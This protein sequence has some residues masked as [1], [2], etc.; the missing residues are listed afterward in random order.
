MVVEWIRINL[1][2]QEKWIPGPGGFH[3]LGPGRFHMP[4]PGRFHMPWSN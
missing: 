3:V 2:M 4:G 1:P